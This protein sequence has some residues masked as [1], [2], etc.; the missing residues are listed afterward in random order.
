MNSLIEPKLIRKLY[1]ASQAG[2]KVDLIVRGMCTLR[3]NIEGISENIKV[4]SVLGQ[5]L[6]HSRVFYF[7]NNQSP[8]MFLSSAD[9]MPRNC[10]RRVETAFPIESPEFRGVILEES[11][12]NYLRDNC[13]AWE[14]QSDGSYIKVASE[15]SPTRHN[16]Q[17]FLMGSLTQ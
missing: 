7:A 3:P 14:L 12:E 5:F 8:E 11:I 13:Y 17:A 9:W 10:F 16:A 2:V 15:G 6:E 1:Q 4:R